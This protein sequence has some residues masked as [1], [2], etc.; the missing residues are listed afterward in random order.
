VNYARMITN[1]QF[2]SRK[3]DKI[4]KKN[5]GT[6]LKNYTENNY[7]TG[8]VPADLDEGRQS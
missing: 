2:L 8:T 7:G 6:S 1:N 4:R 5:N 3:G